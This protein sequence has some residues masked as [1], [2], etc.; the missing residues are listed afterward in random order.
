MSITIF[1]FDNNK[2]RVPFTSR[3]FCGWW[4][5]IVRSRK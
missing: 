2:T 3:H 4:G 5:G 1:K